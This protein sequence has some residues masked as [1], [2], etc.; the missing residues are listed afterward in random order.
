MDTHHSGS[1]VNP[2]IKLKPCGHRIIR[3]PGNLFTL[4]PRH[5][6][7]KLHH[8]AYFHTSVKLNIPGKEFTSFYSVLRCFAVPPSWRVARSSYAGGFNAKVKVVAGVGDL[9]IIRILKSEVGMQA[10]PQ[11]MRHSYSQMLYLIWKKSV[12]H[13]SRE[14][15]E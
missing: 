12:D 13:E 11:M 2:C 6:E 10:S 9:S 15:R 5:A 4:S 14:F 8:S 7:C 1:L 3:T